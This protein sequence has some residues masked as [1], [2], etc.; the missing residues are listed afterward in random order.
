MTTRRSFL[1]A[2]AG[3]LAA[4]S[5]LRRVAWAQG[6]KPPLGLQ[7]W[8][9]RKRLKQ[10]VAGTLKQVK[11]WGFDEVESF[12][13]FGAPVAGKLEDA[14]LRCPS[15]HFDYERLTGDMAGVQRDAEALGLKT[16]VNPYLP[17]KRKPFASREEILRAAGDFAKWAEAFKA[18]GRRFAYH[19]HGQEFAPDGD[20]TLF[21][22]LARESGPDVG[23]EADVYWVTFGGADPLALMKKYA[24]RVWY[25]HLKDMA[26]GIAPGAKAAHRPE[27][28]VALGTGEIDIRDIV[29]E[30]ARI[31][32]S[33]NFLEDES[34]DPFGQIPKSEAFYRTL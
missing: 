6:T 32:V 10:D 17:H 26:K 34:K 30:S 29:G 1:G 12:G 14:G 8:S 3:G 20:G 16:I 24:D 15:M 33:V 22:V 25:T 7:L 31:G 18:S 23:F 21:D 19:I 13:E 28:N 27:S 2:M 9:V 4:S 5:A 11:A